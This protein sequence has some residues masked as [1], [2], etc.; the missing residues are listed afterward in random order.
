MKYTEHRP[1]RPLPME[2]WLFVGFLVLAGFCL[3]AAFVLL[4]IAGSNWPFTILLLVLAA[5]C[6]VYTNF[7]VEEAGWP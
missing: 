6:V 2:R 5:I 3:G 1:D 7:R 4:L